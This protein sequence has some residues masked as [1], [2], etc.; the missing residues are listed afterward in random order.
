MGGDECLPVGATEKKR[1]VCV[2][3]AGV[4]GGDERPDGTR[5][6]REKKVRRKGG[7]EEGRRKEGKG[8]TRA[9]PRGWG[10]GRRRGGAVKDFLVGGLAARVWP[11]G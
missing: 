2:D 8:R 11:A 1:G 9:V 5:R 7:R 4:G 10:V 6:E 3:D